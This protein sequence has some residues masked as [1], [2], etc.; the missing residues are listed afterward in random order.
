MTESRRTGQ[1]TWNR[2]YATTKTTTMKPSTRA[3]VP[4]YG[5]NL[6][7]F[8]GRCSTVAAVVRVEQVCSRSSRN[9][10][11]VMD[12]NDRSSPEIRTTDNVYCHL[13][14]KTL[15]RKPCHR[16]GFF[17]TKR[18]SLRSTKQVCH[19]T[20]SNVSL[21]DV[22]SHSRTTDGRLSNNTLASTNSI[23]TGR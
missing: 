4:N 3:Y 7:F 18:G 15:Q 14:T 17:F 20:E 13:D 11:K 6:G 22:C 19:P 8:F 16:P 1:A 23:K 9:L 21:I 10:P 12:V 2:I 5:R